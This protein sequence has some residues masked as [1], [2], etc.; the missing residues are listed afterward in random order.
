MPTL[1]GTMS[2]TVEHAVPVFPRLLERLRITL[3]PKGDPDVTR[4]H[5]LLDDVAR[6]RLRLAAAVL[7]VT[8]GEVV[9]QALSDRLTVIEQAH[10]EVARVLAAA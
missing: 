5:V 3:H 1:C 4:T 8:Q 6:Q 9:R 10:P 2:A 7:G